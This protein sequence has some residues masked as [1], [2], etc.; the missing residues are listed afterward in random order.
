MKQLGN[1]AIVCARRSDVLLQ[2]QGD[3]VCIYIGTEPQREAISLNWDD[4]NYG[5]YSETEFWKV[6]RKMRKNVWLKI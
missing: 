4:E 3:V 5:A 1:L 6:C 2:I